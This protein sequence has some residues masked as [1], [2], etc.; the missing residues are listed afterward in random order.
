MPT[1]ALLPLTN[2]SPKVTPPTTP[3][4]N[5]RAVK[6]KTSEREKGQKRTHALQQTRPLF[7]H[8]V[9]G[10]VDFKLYAGPTADQNGSAAL[11]LLACCLALG[12][13]RGRL[14]VFARWMSALGH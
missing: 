8:L 14:A 6:S 5:P 4:A 10:V 13:T 1:Q 2:I 7:D 12:D 9:G 11:T 3:A